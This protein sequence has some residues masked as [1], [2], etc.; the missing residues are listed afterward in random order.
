MTQDERPQDWNWVEAQ[1]RC[2]V[3][4]MF[5]RLRE[6]AKRD[7]DQRNKQLNKQAFVLKDIDGITFS[8][9]AVKG[10]FNGQI[11]FVLGNDAI[12]ISGANRVNEVQYT[13]ALDAS[14]TCRFRR[15][16]EE[17]DFWQVLKAALEPL[18]F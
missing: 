7:V 9:S 12:S 17:L 15:G 1:G 16:L 11:F 5:G 8:V 4:V 10:D 14:G 13:V 18:F 6:L 3:E 2:K